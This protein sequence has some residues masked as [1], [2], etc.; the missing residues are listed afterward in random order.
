MN[1]IL[2]LN[3]FYTIKIIRQTWISL[4]RGW[5]YLFLN[6]IGCNAYYTYTKSFTYRI[7]WPHETEIIDTNKNSFIHIYK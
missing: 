4:E 5:S 7:E 3:I 2:L 6:F 1:L